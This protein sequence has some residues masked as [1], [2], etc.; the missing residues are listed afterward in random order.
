VSLA[1]VGFEYS[2]SAREITRRREEALDERMQT[3]VHDWPVPLSDVTDASMEHSCPILHRSFEHHA[4]TDPDRVAIK[5]EDQQL[6]YGELNAQANQLARYLAAEGYGFQHRIALWIEPGLDRVVALLAVFKL[7]AVACPLHTSLPKKLLASIIE[8]AAAGV[9]LTSDEVFEQAG[10]NSDS[11]TDCRIIRV[12]NARTAV[13]EQAI[14][15]L[16]QCSSGTDLAY[17]VH[18]SGSTGAPKAVAMSQGAFSYEIRWQVRQSGSNRP[19]TTLQFASLG[20]DV[21]L[22]EIMATLCQGGM[23]VVATERVRNDSA[24]LLDAIEKYQIERLLISRVVL[25]G[26]AE[27]VIRRNEAP[28]SIKEIMCT[29]EQLTITAEIRQLFK[30]HP[31]LFYNEYGMSESPVVAAHTL[32]GNPEDWPD[33][34][35]AGKVAAD[36]Q[37]FILDEELKPVASGEEGEV[38]VAGKFLA[39]GYLGA[40][41]ETSQKFKD[42][43]FGP[44]R[45]F[46]S[47]DIGRFSPERELVLLGRLDSVVKIRGI[48]V[49]LGEIESLLR[50]HPIVEESVVKKIEDHKDARLA[51]YVTLK[52]Q[53]ESFESTLREWL[54][55]HLPIFAIPSHFIEVDAFPRTHSGK[56]DRRALPLPG[57]NRPKIATPYVAADTHFETKLLAIWRNVLKVDSVGTRDKVFDLGGTSISMQELLREINQELN[58]DLAATDLFRFPSVDVLARHISTTYLKTNDSEVDL[59]VI[60]KDSEDLQRRR[61]R[62][63]QSRLARAIAGDRSHE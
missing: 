13:R 39:E 60:D 4:L 17:I 57:T 24:C 50:N 37:V 56:I 46:K 15:N 49:G 36:A 54:E 51:A 33:I 44:G 58:I 43:P 25:Q 48:R 21:F 10:M 7:G 20:F 45:I 12:A 8:S 18:T 35:P 53:S 30:K 31:C 26:L 34:P 5:F 27:E 16:D 28:L 55:E 52:I 62:R 1:R 38:Y 47:G 32:Q 63:S 23:V 40:D 42:N 29:G 59:Q 19:F 22:T 11:V 6:T 41:G 14:N 2:R 61:T 9:L 3:S